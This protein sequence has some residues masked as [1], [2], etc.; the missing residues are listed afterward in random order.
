MS[1]LDTDSARAWSMQLALLRQELLSPVNA[2]LSYAEIVHEEATRQA[3]PDML[4]DI[5]RILGA[6]RD[7]AGKVD[8]LV[9]GDH[10]GGSAGSAAF[11]QEQALR[12]ELR[13]P[14]NA[15]KGYGEMLCEI[16]TEL[17]AGSLRED[18]GRL[19]TAA[20]DLLPSLDRIV[21]FSV[22]VGTTNLP[23]DRT[24]AGIVADLMK[25]L[26]PARNEPTTA[27]ETGSIL[28]VDDI[29]ANRDILAR[30]LSRDGHRVASAVGGQHA[31]QALSNEAFDLVLLDLMMPDIN[32]FDVLMRMKADPQLQHIPVIMI[33]AVDEVESVVRCIE[34]GA[35]DYVAKPFNPTLLRARVC[36]SLVRKHLLDKVR[37]QAADLA[38][39]NQTL[40]RRVADQVAEIERVSRLQRFLSP[41]V[42]QLII[43]SGDDRVLESH[44]RAIT[45][46]FCDLRGFTAFSEVTEPEEVMAVMREYHAVLGRL[47]HKYEGTVER[48]AGDALMVFFNDPVPCPDPSLRAVQMAI[49]MRDQVS[50]L[51]VKW[52]K[53][54]H[55]LGYGVGIAHGYA[56]LGRI[57]FEG[58]YDYGAV[59]TVVNL[60]A[61]LCADAKHGQILIEGRVH[62]A[63]E[64][65]TNT[66]PTGELLLK[67]IH[68]PVNTF[69]VVAMR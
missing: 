33:S 19:L 25:S 61:R 11:T 44:R 63:I 37:A 26:G 47:V 9:E 50:S 3:R 69:N 4:P 40:E 43:S 13:T 15:I 46:L 20:S 34:I 6:A 2:L 7:L 52:H 31:L 42:A 39:W 28:I 56:T 60:A 29:E 18:L 51:L 38:A 68:R 32:G 58:R 45:V 21:R 54:G 35:E 27:F 59:G 48:F 5:S 30:R 14:I 23:P 1:T 10:G 24:E 67:G 57:G 64:A 66:E 16:V 53:Q 62:S 65:A 36:A 17:P 49:E 41:Q 12:H 22:D 8:R 55:D